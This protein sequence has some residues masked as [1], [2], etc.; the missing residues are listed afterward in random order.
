MYSKLLVQWLVHISALN[1][2]WLYLFFKAT[3]QS[4]EG[5]V[6]LVLFFKKYISHQKP[7]VKVDVEFF[8]YTTE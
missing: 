7:R 5:R 3:L 2:S 1:S 6:Y 8:F 4:S